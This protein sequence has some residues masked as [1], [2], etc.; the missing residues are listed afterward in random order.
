MGLLHGPLDVLRVV[1]RPP[2]DDHVLE[3]PDHEELAIPEE[4]QVSGAE[5]GA[6]SSPGEGGTEGLLTLVGA[7]PVTLRHGRIRDPDLADLVRAK[8]R[9]SLRI[10]DREA[11]LR[12]N[13]A[14][15]DDRP[16]RLAAAAGLDDAMLLERP[17]LQPE[18]ERFFVDRAEGDHQGRFGQAVRR[19]KSGAAE[20]VRLERRMEP[21]QDV[22]VDHL[23]T[24]ASR[25]QLERSSPSRRFWGMRRTH[26]S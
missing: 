21:I 15:T 20:P 17:C 24:V 8:S 5:E 3:P 19:A 4:S 6:G 11:G 16:C 12:K 7:L 10:D 1:I 2:D 14:A 25:A 26:R 9:S 18:H 22:G 23:G 13:P